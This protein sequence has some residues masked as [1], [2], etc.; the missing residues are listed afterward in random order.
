MDEEIAKLILN[1]LYISSSI[2]SKGISEDGKSITGTLMSLESKGLIKYISNDEYYYVLSDEGNSILENGSHEYIFYNLISSKGMEIEESKKYE[3]GKL[4]AFK[5]QWVV[6]RGDR[7]YKNVC[8]ITDDVCESLKEINCNN[9][10]KKISNEMLNSLIKRKLIV[11]K[12]KIEYSIF[13]GVNYCNE[14]EKLETDL[15]HKMVLDGSYKAKSFKSYNFD[16]SGI[17]PMAGELHPMMKIREEFRKIFLEMGFEEMP[18]NRYVETSFWNF[19]ALFQPQNHPSRD[20]HDTFFTTD[21]FTDEVVPE[22]YLERVKNVHM[23]G[24]YGSS[25]YLYEFDEKETRRP[26][27][28]THTT[29]S[30]CRL[31]Y[32][33]AAKDFVPGKYFSIDKVF[34]NESVDATHLAEFHQVEGVVVGKNIGLGHLMAIIKQFFRKLNM[35]RIKFKPA[36]NPYTEPSMEVFAYHEGL[37]KWIEVGNSGVFRPE[38]LKP[39][40]FED[41]VRV[42]G[43]G[44]SLERPTMIKYNVSNIRKL[45]GHKVEFQFIKDSKICYF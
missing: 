18:T 28:R 40:G 26:V 37:K 16:S 21:E 29:A 7:I 12:K 5:K 25:G 30:S 17:L 41:N 32:Q 14:I 22:K 39:M 19:D 3:I 24:G 36:Y 2:T 6:K 15:T 35:D 13:R 23:R 44:L 27:L 4:N 20:S 33:L 45:V 11:K 31:L 9:F 34:R 10:S 42:L 38:M 43:W 1:K 8:E